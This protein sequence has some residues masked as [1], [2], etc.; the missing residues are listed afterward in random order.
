MVKMEHRRQIRILA[1]AVVILLPAIAVCSPM[2]AQAGDAAPPSLVEVYWKSSRTVAV[3]GI[4]NLIVLDQDIARVESGNDTVQ[5]WGLERGETVVLGYVGSKPVSMRV[6]VIERP[7]IPISPSLLRRQGEMVQGSFGSNVQTSRSDGISTLALLNSFSWSQPFSKDSR[8]DFNSQIEDYTYEGS[9]P[10]N[11][12]QATILYHSPGVDVHA[13]DFSASLTGDSSQRFL[14]PFS[15]SDMLQLRGGGVTLRRGD[16][17]YSLYGGTTI[18]YYFLTLGSTRDVAG[19]SFQHRESDKLAV[20]AN[21]AFINAPLD[22]LGL[23]T[24]RRNN[25]MQTAGVT[26]LP[27]KA[28]SAQ[29]IGGISNHGGLG[30]GEFAYSG[31]RMLVYGSATMSSSL[32][33]L[34]QIESILAGTSAFKG[35]WTFKSSER[36]TEF[37]SYQH[38]ITKAISAIIHDG[39]SDYVSPGFTAKITK[40]QD[41]SFNYAYSRNSGGFTTDPSTGNRI[42]INWHSQMTQRVSNNAQITVGSLQDPLQVNSEDQFSFRDSVSFPV[43]GGSLVAA[44]EHDRSNPSLVQKLNSELALLSPALQTLFLSDP[45]SFVNSGNLP[46]E[47][48]AL[49]NAQQPIST[50]VSCT[51]QFRLA[52]KLTLNPNSSFAQIN[53]GHT[54]SWA[55]Y[56]GYGLMYQVRPTLQLTSGLNT[57]WVLAKP[58]VTL[59]R[60][61]ILSFGFTKFFS[62]MPVSFSPTHRDRVIEGRVFRDNKV[63]GV[64]SA[65]DRGLPGIE[66]RL[67]NGDVAITDELGRYK[68]SG[69][70]GGE[71][72][73]LLSLTQ[74]REPVRMTTRNEVNVDLIRQR[75]AIA[76]FGVV[77]FARLMGNVF[78]DLR[79]EGKRQPDSKGMQGV[80]MVLDDGRQK[81]T[82]TTQG[83]GD[84]E[85][86][87]LPPGDYTLTIDPASLP[88]NYTLPADSFKLHVSPVSNVLQDVPV[89]A[90]RSIAGRVFLKVSADPT[91]DP[92]KLNVTGVPP[93]AGQSQGGKRVGQAGGQA[94]GAA[95]TPAGAGEYKLVPMADIQITAGSVIAKTD[96][97]GNFLLRDL[98]AGDLTITLVPLRPLPEGMK[99]PSGSV[100]M[101]SEPIQVQGAT[102]VISNPDLVPY[103]V[104][105]SAAQVRDDALKLESKSTAPAT[106]VEPASK[107]ANTPVPPANA[108][109]IK[110]AGGTP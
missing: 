56:F 87:D 76:D 64:F 54:D 75:I 47:I 110:P 31:R 85:V 6:R 37:V 13:M 79:F 109:K 4:T 46:P 101:P 52:N 53:N 100:H 58:G 14:S 49:L 83:V 84:Y 107:P 67:E 65:G 18:P 42:D 11:I 48:R 99:V 3:P 102:I 92:G 10:V 41:L 28:W 81:R 61:T 59:Q 5:I 45:V 105:K 9:H 27:S 95:Q 8:L 98:P 29:M 70:T 12:R 21:T 20:F 63:N 73:V 82:V 16:N 90:L 25:V 80:R 38:T 15:Y 89:R 74:F 51:G 24:G 108:E 78:N 19:F 2:L 50:A 77:N 22:F 35:G 91:V 1:A 32:F 7:V 103:L 43:K 26:F 39:S 72:Q 68:F 40:N 93:G 55:P 57:L 44:F 23:S 86:D 71:H 62:A 30:R 97:Y 69:V 96:A 88:A 104:G 60:T 34:N 106:T 94:G 17:Q 36:L 66:V 33:P